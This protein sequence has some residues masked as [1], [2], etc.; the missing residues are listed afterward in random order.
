MAAVYGTEGAAMLIEQAA[1]AVRALPAC[2]TDPLA[3]MPVGGT[4]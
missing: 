3:T 1:K 2:P 4:A